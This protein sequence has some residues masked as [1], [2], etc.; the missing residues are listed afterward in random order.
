[1]TVQE[2]IEEKRQEGL[3]RER[4]IAKY[5]DAYLQRERELDEQFKVGRCMYPEITL[6]V[7]FP[8]VR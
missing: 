2:Y 8:V 7:E 1:M 6:A 5:G 3:D 4:R